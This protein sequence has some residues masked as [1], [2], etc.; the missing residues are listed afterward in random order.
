MYS[1]TLELNVLKKSYKYNRYIF[2][3]YKR[4]PG[5]C[6]RECEISPVRCDNV[7]RYAVFDVVN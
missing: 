4:P 1:D 5:R 2:F 3:Q 7:A 6:Y